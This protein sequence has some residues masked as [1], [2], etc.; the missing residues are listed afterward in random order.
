MFSAEIAKNGDR[1][2]FPFYCNKRK[3]KH[4][5][6]KTLFVIIR[7]KHLQLYGFL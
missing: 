3:W 2:K 6:H 5:S 7:P 1:K 4:L